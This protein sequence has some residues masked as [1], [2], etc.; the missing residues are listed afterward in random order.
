MVVARRRITAAGNAKGRAGSMHTTFFAEGLPP[1]RKV[2]VMS[3][4][5]FGAVTKSF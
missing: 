2:A 4:S 5:M 1:E 3:L